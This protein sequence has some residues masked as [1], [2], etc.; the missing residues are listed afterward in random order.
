MLM[1]LGVG[2]EEVYGERPDKRSGGGGGVEEKGKQEGEGGPSESP[3]WED[4]VEEG[5]RRRSECPRDR[6]P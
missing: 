1:V 2:K 6:S 3:L 4:K 5:R